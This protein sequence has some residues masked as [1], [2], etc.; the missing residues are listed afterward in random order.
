MN[1]TGFWIFFS[2]FALI[3]AHTFSIGFKSGEYGGQSITVI[4]YLCRIV[5][6]PTTN[7]L[8]NYPS[9]IQHY[10]SLKFLW[11]HLNYYLISLYIFCIK[12]FSKYLKSYFSICW[13]SSQWLIFCPLL[14]LFVFNILFIFLHPFITWWIISIDC[15]FIGEKYFIPIFI[16]IS[17][18][19]V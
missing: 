6:L 16:K 8:Y 11:T 1:S 12:V 19:P 14:L 10:R 5:M 15:S 17:S 7:E 18:T 2:N 13:N 9:V 3:N 4:Y